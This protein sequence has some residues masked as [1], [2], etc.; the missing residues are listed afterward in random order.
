[1]RHLVVDELV[2]GDAGADLDPAVALADRHRVAAIDR[3]GAM[4]AAKRL[5]VREFHVPTD[6]S[7]APAVGGTAQAHATAIKNFAF[8]VDDRRAVAVVARRVVG[9][10]HEPRVVRIH[11]DAQRLHR[12]L[13][14]AAV[15]DAVERARVCAGAREGRGPT[16]AVCGAQVELHHA[17]VRMRRD[18]TDEMIRAVATH[19][20]R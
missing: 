16:V 19:G 10:V 17:A 1:M 7:T 6:T 20:D 15:A 2:G 11:D 3:D 13:A 5:V 14:D 8:V 12:A 4:H 9:D 18:D